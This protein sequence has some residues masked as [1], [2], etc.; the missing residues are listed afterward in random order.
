MYIFRGRG[1]KENDYKVPQVDDEISQMAE[2]NPSD[3]F[4]WKAEGMI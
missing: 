2:I 3:T 4:T 1:S